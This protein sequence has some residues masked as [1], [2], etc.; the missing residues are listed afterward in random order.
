V[1]V[2]LPAIGSA[3]RALGSAT[4]SPRELPVPATSDYSSFCLICASWYFCQHLLQCSKCR[5][6]IFRWVH[7]DDLR[8]LR[9][10]SSLGS[11]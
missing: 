6:D 4:R 5:A 1:S 8:F 3:G 7:T 10:R 11:M 9:S 2:A